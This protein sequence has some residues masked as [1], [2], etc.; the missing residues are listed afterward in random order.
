MINLSEKQMQSLMMLAMSEA[1][2]AADEGNFPFG[3]VAVD[4]PGKVISRAHNTQNTM[5]DPTA[6]AEM[7]LIRT[8]AKILKIDGWGKL[9]LICN[10]ESCSMCFSA[11]IKAGLRHFIFGAACEA[12]MDPFQPPAEIARFSTTELDIVNGVMA[13]EC[14][15]Q[16]AAIRKSQNNIAQ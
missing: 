5:H 6:H 3:A 11:A 10:A 1:Q 4:H 13:V 8:L 12:H 9:T 14:T 15:Q 7:N 16:I 2:I